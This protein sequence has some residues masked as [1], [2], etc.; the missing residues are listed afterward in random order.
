MWVEFSWNVSPWCC[1]ALLVCFC[2]D[3]I[4]TCASRN[5]SYN[6]SCSLWF[7]CNV[8]I[9]II[10][11]YHPDQSDGHYRSK[12]A[13]IAVVVSGCIIIIIITV[14]VIYKKKR[15]CSSLPECFRSTDMMTDNSMIWKP[16][17]C[18]SQLNLV[19]RWCLWL[20]DFCF[21]CI[22]D[23]YYCVVLMA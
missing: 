10:L 12:V 19:K 4:Q 13:V 2:T 21:I 16:F 14:T 15:N 20:Y 9:E 22:Y 6:K 7:K 23:K 8:P 18:N 5:H 3:N 17:Y 11:L 1:F